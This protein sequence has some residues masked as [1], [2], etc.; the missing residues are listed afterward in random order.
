M[1]ELQG[2]RPAIRFAAAR[3][4]LVALLLSVVLGL[5]TAWIGANAVYVPASTPTGE[6]LMPLWK[7]LSMCAAVIPVLGLHSSLEDLDVVATSR[8]RRMENLYLAT[9]SGVGAMVFV[10]LAAVALP[11]D[12]LLPMIR[13]LPT[14]FGLALLSG[15]VAGW[16]LAWVLPLTAGTMLIYLAS[17]DRIEWWDITEP[18]GSWGAYGLSVVC[19]LVGLCAHW[20]TAW[21]R[22][23]LLTLLRRAR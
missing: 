12:Q 13:S 22:R 1:A 19:L 6:T 9:I 8:L 15:R 11:A 2:F 4:G 5:T 21:R 18:T 20:L 23:S 7:P 10:G 14:W 3:N 17:G 16:R